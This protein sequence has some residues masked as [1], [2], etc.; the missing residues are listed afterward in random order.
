[1]NISELIKTNPTNLNTMLSEILE[2]NIENKAM[3]QSI[4][5]HISNNDS[6]K[7]NELLKIADE[8]KNKELLRVIARIESGRSD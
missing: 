1:M 4:I 2:T 3:L 5:L 8:I 6:D 7:V